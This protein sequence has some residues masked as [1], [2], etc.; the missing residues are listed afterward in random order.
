MRSP[1]SLLFSKLDKPEVLSCSSQA[2]PSSPVTICVAL[3]WTHSRT[4][5]FFF[6]GGAQ[7]RRGQAPGE[8]APAPNA[9][10]QLCLLT[11]LC[12]MNPGMGFALWAARAGCWLA[13]SLLPASTPRSLSAGL[14]PSHSSPHLYVW[15]ALLHPRCRIWHLCMLNLWLVR[16]KIR[17]HELNLSLWFLYIKIFLRPYT[18]LKSTSQKVFSYQMFY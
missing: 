10:G 15:P 11:A 14:L 6:N 2:M 12:L 13:L 5:M 7:N 3:L 9:A 4:L 18:L 1:L 16:Q 17:H 8:A